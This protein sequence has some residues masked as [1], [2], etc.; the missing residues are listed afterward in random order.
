MKSTKYNYCVLMILDDG[1][2]MLAYFHKGID[3][4]QKNY[5]NKKIKKRPHK[6][7]KDSHK[8]KRFKR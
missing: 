6:R 2:H 4:Y 8:K 3:S 7:K 1:I 5:N